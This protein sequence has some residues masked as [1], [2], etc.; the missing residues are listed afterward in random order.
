[1]V[2][3]LANILKVAK[4]CLCKRISQYKQALSKD[5]VWEK[6]KKKQR[7]KRKKGR[8]KDRKEKKKRKGVIEREKSKRKC[9]CNF[10]CLFAC[11]DGVC[12]YISA[13]AFI[14]LAV[15]LKY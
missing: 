10:V 8:E 13:C 11:E 5:L 6:K 3:S 7:Q 4:L 1:M 12:V 15:L 2:L 9:H 14:S